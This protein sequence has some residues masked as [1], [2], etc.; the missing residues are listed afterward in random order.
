MRY[1]GLVAAAMALA[2]TFTGLASPAQGDDSFAAAMPDAN[3]RKCVTDKLGLPE[4]AEPTAEQLDSIAELSCTS[5]DIGDVTGTDALTGI[6]KLFLGNNRIQDIAPL[7]QSTKIFSLGLQGNRISDITPLRGLTLLRSVNLDNNRL[8]D[9][10]TLAALPEWTTIGGGTRHAQQATN[11]S[12]AGRTVAVPLVVGA[13]GNTVPPTPP[14]GVS[15][16]GGDVTYP[17]EGSY[18]WSFRDEQDLSFNGTVT[19]EVGTATD[20]T[21][22]DDAFRTC[23]NSRIG[24]DPDSQPSVEELSG[25]T[26]ALTCSNKGVQDLRGAEFLT[27]VTA[28]RLS[29]NEIRDVSPLRGLPNLTSLDLAQNDVTSLVGLGAMPRLGT[30][31]IQQTASSTKPRLTS[32]AGVEKLTSLTSLTVNHQ[33]QTSLAPLAGHPSLRTLTATHNAFTDVSPLADVAQLNSV[34]LDRNEISDLSPLEGKQFSKLQVFDQALTADEV[35]ASERVPA[36]SVTKQDG[37][38]LVATPPA[39]ISVEDGTVTYPEAGSYE[40][41]FTDARSPFPATFTGSITQ[42]VAPAPDPVE[43]VE[44]PDTNLRACFNG[45]LDQ[46]SA[47]PISKEM[48]AELDEISCV[49]DGIEDLTGVEH[50]T[51]ATEINLATNTFS[52]LTPLGGL[53]NLRTLNFPGNQVGD[54]APLAGLTDLTK[55]N[56]SYNPVTR[57]TQIETL[58]DLVELDVT[59]RSGSASHPGIDSLDGVQ[60][61]TGLTRLVA[62][63]SRITDLEPVAGLTELRSLFVNYNQV[64]DLSPL[65]GLTQLESLGVEY[66]EVGDVSPLAGLRELRTIGLN[67]NR[68]ADVSPLDG[69]TKLGFLEPRARW[70]NVALE[71]VPADMALNQPR[72]TGLARGPV[73]LTPPDEATIEDGR[74]TYPAPGSYTWAWTA[75]TGDGEYFSGTATQPVGDPAPAAAHIPDGN[76]RACVAEAAGL[77]PGAAPTEDDVAQLSKIDCADRGISDLTGLELALAAVSI[78]LSGN[79]LVDVAPLAGLA[80]LEELVIDGNHIRDLSP[81]GGLDTEISATGQRLATDDARGGVAVQAPTVVSSDGTSVPAAAPEGHVLEDGAVTF[82]RAGDYEWPF[83]AMGGSFSGVFAQRIT[84]DVVDE[85]VHDGAAQC[86]AD[87]DV[88][89]VVERDTGLQEGGCATEFENGVEALFSAGFIVNGLES[90]DEATAPEFVSEIDGYPAETTDGSWYWG[91]FHG[92]DPQDVVEERDG[93]VVT[94]RTFD[95]EYSSL[96]VKQYAPEP[97]TI[98]AFRFQEWGEDTRIQEPTWE[99]VVTYTADAACEISAATAGRRLVGSTTYLWGTVADCDA[100]SVTVE[101]LEGATWVEL[102]DAEVSED[103]SYRF[104]LAGADTR[105]RHVLRAIADEATSEEVALTRIGRT[106]VAAATRTATGRTANVWG[107]VDGDATVRTQVYLA[108]RGWVSSQSREARGGYVVPLTYGQQTPGTYRWRVVVEHGHGEREISGTFVQ[109]RLSPPTAVWTDPA[110]AG[111]TANVWGTV[112]GRGE[113]AVWTEVRLPDGRWVRSR[114]GFTNASGGYVI[115]LTYG[116]GTPGA[117]RW[118]VASEYPGLGV[119]YSREFVLTR[120]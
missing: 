49:G 45:H 23:I 117:T 104:S 33:G 56:V 7:A 30:L 52:D 71:E 35:T 83:A 20:E 61:M 10:S 80:G 19:V 111:R 63:N 87:D 99:P 44:I 2:L 103:G 102:G 72:I 75:R 42:R 109:R 38:T 108:G 28:L 15:V 70:Q 21:V 55:L 79:S 40:W 101:T 39:P 107:T 106:T 65:T 113:A 112:D 100:P 16:S 5:R 25:L 51:S 66:N 94:T 24:A 118:R 48:L 6:T 1:R 41:S 85:S 4:G 90:Y 88:W 57:L 73:T 97:G 22:P 29:R 27:S 74:V 115:P 3:Y 53:E 86:L 32:L 60:A 120:R 14:E 34:I 95:W 9:I 18:V 50:L 92:I 67:G 76:L 96:A 26:G 110:F 12:V 46:D 54:L 31:T 105:G 43:D 59:Q 8:S 68:I 93:L 62:N 77:G 81:L 98:E 47:A 82:A 58:V 64:D 91:Y 36:P 13:R 17:E 114:A 11:Q 69:L 84:T 37:T 78:D 119:L 116:A 89:V